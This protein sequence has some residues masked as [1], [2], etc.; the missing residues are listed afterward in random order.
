[1]AQNLP[2][3]VL[4][5]LD[6]LRWDFSEPIWK[7][8]KPLGFVKYKAI[9]PSNWTLPSHVSMFTGLYPSAHGVHETGRRKVPKIK[10]KT[11]E[12]GIFDLLIEEGYSLYFLTANAFITPA[13]GFPSNAHV[14]LVKL[15][16]E[17]LRLDETEK[18]FLSQILFRDKKTKLRLLITSRKFGIL[19]KLILNKMYRTLKERLERWPLSKGCLEIYHQLNTV[20][21][22]ENNTPMFIFVNFMEMHEPYPNVH[23][24]LNKISSHLTEK[25]IWNENIRQKL[26]KAYQKELKYL[27]P[28]FKTFIE[29][30]LH[31]LGK[32]SLV[33]VTSD[34][35]QILGEY[36]EIFHLYGVYSELVEVPLFIKSQ[37]KIC[38]PPHYWV[39]LT[40][41]YRL[42]SSHI[43][44]ASSSV[45]PIGNEIAISECFGIHLPEISL[46]NEDI[47]CP[48]RIKI[49]YR[50]Y[51]AEKIN[52]EMRITPK[53]SNSTIESKFREIL[54]NLDF[55]FGESSE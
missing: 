39:S 15:S 52:E 51:Q 3:I 30:L 40:E 29:T 10:W 48:R 54:N 28:T 50:Q 37:K 17:L 16:N 38:K 25:K 18:E 21:G 46:K 47:T 42:I 24:P 41:T 49:Y 55:Y 27:L 31:S 14:H 20:I 2:N 32:D 1:V 8:L 11:K 53:P 5:V 35:G 19:T 43:F 44:D 36:P 26:Y 12:K 13:F 4:I 7:L 6:C 9:A 34:H 22:K 45:F 33:I 23:L